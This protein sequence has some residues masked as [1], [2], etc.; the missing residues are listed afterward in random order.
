MGD[1]L[2]QIA[3][4]VRRFKSEHNLTLGSELARLQLAATQDDIAQAL[5]SAE[6]DL[7]S[8][9]RA[10]VVEITSQ[11]DPQLIPLETVTD[12]QISIER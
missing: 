11:A 3:S 2:I 8:V 12:I 6:L 10:R 4:A 9:C 7:A 5:R 1:K